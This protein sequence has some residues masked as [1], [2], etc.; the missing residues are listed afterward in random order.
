MSPVR[1]GRTLIALFTIGAILSLSLPTIPAYALGSPCA[2]DRSNLIFNGAMREGGL[3]PWGPVSDGWSA[4]VMNGEPPTFDHADNEGIDPYGSQYIFADNQQYDAG[5]YQV[6]PNLQPGTYYHFWVGYALAAYD[7][8]DTVNRRYDQI[9]RLIGVDPMGGTD[10]HGPAVQ[11]GPETLN[12][13]AALKIP[14]MDGTFAAQAD[15]VTVFV[16]AIN[17]SS[18]YRNKVW[19]DSICMEPRTDLPT[20]TPAATIT[21]TEAPTNTPRPTRVP[22]TSA[23]ATG[24]PTDEPT[25]VPT[26]TSTPTLTNTPTITPTPTETPKPRRVIPIPSPDASGPGGNVLPTAI[27][28][29][30]IG[31]LSFSGLGIVVLI[32]FL[33]WQ[34]VRHRASRGL[35]PQP[36]PYTPTYDE[37]DQFNEAIEPRLPP[38][39]QLPGDIF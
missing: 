13:K 38:D 28:V 23:P 27:I 37:M 3:S 8:G 24:I 30:S 17:H 34:F 18:Q 19:F 32:G 9:G 29:G 14:A 10:P 12:G 7:N 26:A 33:L 25:E 6:V 1:R 11:W 36:Y 39:E 15:H 5:I 31:V 2:L 20:A 16:R 22:A 35:K 4:F 21:P